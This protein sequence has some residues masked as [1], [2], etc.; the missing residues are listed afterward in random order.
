MNS[1]KN[2]LNNKRSGLFS[3]YLKRDLKVNNCGSYYQYI[4]KKYCKLM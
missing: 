2:K 3:A 4:I 1:S